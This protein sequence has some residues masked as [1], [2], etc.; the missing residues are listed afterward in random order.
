MG[1]FSNIDEY[2]TTKQELVVA[3][4]GIFEINTTRDKN[5]IASST[6]KIL[7]SKEAF[8]EAYNKY[9]KNADDEISNDTNDESES[10]LF[11]VTLSDTVI[12][13]IEANDKHSAE[14]KALEW[15]AQRTPNIITKQIVRP[16]SFAS[17]IG[18]TI[19]FDE[20]VESFGGMVNVYFMSDREMAKKYIDKDY[21]NIEF[22]EINATESDLLNP[23]IT[24]IMCEM[25]P[26]QLEDD[27][28][29]DYD[30]NSNIQ[31]D[32]DDTKALKE[33][34]KFIIS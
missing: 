34:Y 10:K 25:S 20:K 8:I 23:N 9:I 31:L 5:G 24:N 6:A 17:G 16:K 11:K 2:A 7:M 14:E 27:V 15:F 4:E 22:C 13:E 30:W 28:F 1:K 33:C 18:S 29:I 32:E 12:Y 19:T 21:D 3:D 26:V